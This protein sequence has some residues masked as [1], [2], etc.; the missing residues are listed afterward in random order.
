MRTNQI[1]FHRKCS[2]SMT[3]GGCNSLWGDVRI[4]D[5]WPIFWSLCDSIE[6]GSFFVSVLSPSFDVFFFPISHHM[7]TSSWSY[8]VAALLFFVLFLQPNKF[9]LVLSIFPTTLDRCCRFTSPQ[10]LFFIPLPHFSLSS[11]KDICCLSGIKNRYKVSDFLVRELSSIGKK[12]VTC[13]FVNDNTRI[14]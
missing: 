3:L 13:K 8:S 2:F 6:Q 11:S 1:L 4:T 9:F 14:T 7:F 10:P 5:S 12:C